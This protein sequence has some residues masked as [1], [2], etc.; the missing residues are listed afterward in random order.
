[1]VALFFVRFSLGFV[2]VRSMGACF[3]ACVRYC[4]VCLCVLLLIFGGVARFVIVCVLFLDIM[5]RGR[6]C[7]RAPLAVGAWLSG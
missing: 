7:V 2:A 3:L 4:S 6:V 5:L 1:M